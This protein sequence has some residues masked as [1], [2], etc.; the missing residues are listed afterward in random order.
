MLYSRFVYATLC[1]TSEGN[2]LIAFP[3]YSEEQ[4][5]TVSKAIKPTC[6]R[7]EYLE[8]KETVH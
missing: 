4:L 2:F 7:V 8:A 5:K 3:V 6:L 1:F